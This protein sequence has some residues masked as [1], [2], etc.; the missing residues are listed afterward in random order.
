MHKKLHFQPQTSSLAS[1][2]L[3]IV[4]GTLDPEQPEANSCR[5]VNANA[6]VV[7][8]SRKANGDGAACRWL[9]G[10][11]LHGRVLDLGGFG[12]NYAEATSINGSGQICGSARLVSGVEQAALWQRGL[13]RN[14]GSL[15]G[16][17]TTSGAFALTEGDNPVVYGFSEVAR[18]TRQAVC[19]QQMAI[20]RLEH[21]TEWMWSVAKAVTLNNLAAGTAYHEVDSRQ[22]CVIWKPGAQELPGLEG[23][24]LPEVRAGHASGYLVGFSD[25]GPR[26]EA[27]AVLFNAVQVGRPAVKIPPLSRV[28]RSFATGVNAHGV[29][30]GGFGMADYSRG[31]FAYAAQE[32]GEMVDLTGL[33]DSRSLV[34]SVLEAQSVNDDGVILAQC[35]R[36]EDDVYALLW[37][38]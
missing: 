14:L 36:G 18:G 21:K 37:P 2:Y 3:A 19:W 20:R 5:V 38:L 17:E 29:V 9:D 32:E 10:G 11:G 24:Q 23:A 1:S 7:G 12:G 27:H 31:G 35:R 22:I 30:V 4:L 28:V 8:L 6:V 16:A 25:T 26:T 33:L 34:A 15:A 13:V